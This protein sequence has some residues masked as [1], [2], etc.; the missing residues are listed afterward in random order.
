MRE[1]TA[2]IGKGRRGN[3]FTSISNNQKYTIKIKHEKL[4][5]TE[6]VHD[7]YL[8]TVI[9]CHSPSLTRLEDMITA[10]PLPNS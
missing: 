3:R 2:A 4:H 6:N 9:V 8:L 10:R 1:L 5:L 7:V